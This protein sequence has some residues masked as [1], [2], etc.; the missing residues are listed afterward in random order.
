M[1]RGYGELA[2]ACRSSIGKWI[3]DDQ[4]FRSDPI[5]IKKMD[6]GRYATEN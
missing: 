1:K 3:D 4:L 5:P 2:R 6:Y